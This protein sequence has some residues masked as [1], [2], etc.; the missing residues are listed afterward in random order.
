MTMPHDATSRRVE[1]ALAAHARGWVLTPLHGKEAYLNGWQKRPAP[2]RED[3]VAWATA[4]N[5][6]VRTGRVSGVVIVDVDVHR[7]GVI[8]AWAEAAPRVR[9]GRGGAHCYFAWPAEPVRNS[10]DRVAP[11]VEILGDGK[12]AVYAGS[13]HPETGV[14][15]TWEIEPGAELPPFP[16]DVAAT[17]RAA[18][19]PKAER[20]P[21]RVLPSEGP[22]LTAYGRKAIDLELDRVRSAPEGRRNDELNGAAY[23]LGQLHAGGEIP[24]VRDDLEASARE[25]GLGEGEARKT[26]ES[27]WRAG[28]EKP[29]TRK[30]KSPRRPDP[31]AQAAPAS[32]RPEIMFSGLGGDIPLHRLLPPA[33]AA[34]AAQCADTVYAR[35]DVLSRVV[36]TT[37]PA[38]DGIRRGSAPRIVRLP[39]PILRERLDEAVCWIREKKN[40]QGDVV[41]LEE[42]CPRPIVDAMRERAAW[43]GVRPLLGVV[44]APTMRPDGSILDRPGYDEKTA[45]IYEPAQAYPAVPESPSEADVAAAYRTLLAPFR[46]FPVSTPADEAAIAALML[47]IACRF[48]IPG[49]V[50]MTVVIAPEFGSGKTLL[51]QAAARAM[52]GHGPDAMAPVGGRRSDGEAEMR[53]RLTTVVMEAPRVAL[54]DNIPDGSTLESPSFAALLTMPQWT[55]RVLGVNRQV[56]L[57]H[58]VVWTVTGNN[59]RVAGDL[60]RRSL[61]IQID[62]G[63]ERPSVRTFEGGDLFEEVGEQH[64][65]LL[66]AALTVMRGFHVAGRPGH[67]RPALGMFTAWDRFIRAAVVWAHRLA[68]GEADPFDTQAR[69]VGEAPDREMLSALLSAWHDELGVDETTAAEVVRRATMTPALLDAVVGVGAEHGGKCDAKKLGTYVRKVAG[70]VVGGFVLER[71][72]ESHGVAKWVVR[73]V[74]GGPR[75]G[76]QGGPGGPVR[77]PSSF[78]YVRASP[79]GVCAKSDPQGSPQSPP[80]PPD[81]AINADAGE[82]VASVVDAS[83]RWPVCPRC[84]RTDR[85]A[86]ADD[87]CDYCRQFLAAKG[88]IPPDPRDGPAPGHP[89]DERWS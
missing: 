74:G 27:G 20:P 40:R 79:A 70:K 59:I 34:L 60:A 7:G 28:V 77:S 88:V 24:D 73:P 56:T 84:N 45:L 80:S 32:A 37:E 43:P 39:D 66:V 21:L 35:G 52:T 68:G 15:Y 42:W 47:Q 57:P 71:R 12:Q 36:T 72:G 19:A 87:G 11:G 44:T 64:P 26:I 31:T 54:I 67:G 63:V 83:P 58:R 38:E 85:E 10:K 17:M 1:L 30:P 76:G 29:R 82:A 13:V 65:Q 89:G 25:A 6:G 9:T 69:L 48:A 4:G 41:R 8:P 49:C 61:S 53:K 3:V 14:V 46:Q 62:P 50:P 75:V 78:V 51:A 86:A 5:V 81:P 23:N 22:G 16:E 55:D 33:V 2:S 18:K